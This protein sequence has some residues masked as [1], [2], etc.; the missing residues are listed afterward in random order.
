ML[1]NMLF[2]RVESARKTEQLGLTW[3]ETLLNWTAVGLVQ[4]LMRQSPWSELKKMR[5]F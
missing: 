3:S 1:F 4:H 5:V 2:Q